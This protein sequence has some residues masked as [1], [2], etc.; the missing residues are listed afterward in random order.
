MTP[1]TISIAL[2]LGWLA[3]TILGVGIAA[4]MYSIGSL[5]A[6]TGLGVTRMGP[7]LG[8]RID[9]TAFL[10]DGSK[11]DLAWFLSDTKPTL[12]IFLPNPQHIEDELIVDIRRFAVLSHD[13]IS[14]LVLGN[15]LPGEVQTSL[16]QHN[17]VRSVELS[18]SDLPAR[19][20]V[21]VT[22]YSLLVNPEG[23]VAAKGLV[24]FLPHLCFLIASSSP[25]EH[26]NE[27]RRTISQCRPYLPGSLSPA[28]G[29]M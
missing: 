20:G 24:N 12:L 10:F 7:P 14:I 4:M 5:Y 28:I 9:K 25:A 3:A 2:G 1:A 13:E 17:N 8:K 27:L 29:G 11:H 26:S 19:L 16:G 21:R 15:L 23:R 18:N 6:F 22:P